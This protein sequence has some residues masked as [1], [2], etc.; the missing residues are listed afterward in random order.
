MH[1]FFRACSGACK[2]DA[3]DPFLDYKTAKKQA[4]KNRLLEAVFFMVQQGNPNP[5]H[6]CC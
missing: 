3:F 6:F 5:N 2:F 1:S 4:Q